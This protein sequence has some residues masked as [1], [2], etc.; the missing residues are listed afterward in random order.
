MATEGRPESA[1]PVSARSTTSW[2]QSRTKAE[3]SSRVAE[4]KT[5]ATMSGLRPMVSDSVP[6]KIIEMASVAVVAET[7]SED[8]AAETPNSSAKIGIS[9]WTQ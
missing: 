8:V 5:E 3:R 7:A 2:C 9:G 4:L 1:I 6:A